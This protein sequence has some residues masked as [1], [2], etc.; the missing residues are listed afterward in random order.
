VGKKTTA[1]STSDL[2][3]NHE[4][5]ELSLKTSEVVTLMHIIHVCTLGRSQLCDVLTTLQST[6]FV[7]QLPSLFQRWQGTVTP[8]SCYIW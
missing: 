1:Q 6:L 8:S 5:S 2:L 7:V 4:I 3:P